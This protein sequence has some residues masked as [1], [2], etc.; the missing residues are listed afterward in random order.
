MW[1]DLKFSVRMLRQT[2]AFS[3]LAIF[4]IA[5]GIGVNTA[6]F[7]LVNAVLFR[8]PAVKAPGE[9]R[10]VYANDGAYSGILMYR[11]YQQLR[12]AAD[13]FVD[14]VAVTQD[15]AKLGRGSGVRL[16]MGE[17]VSTN[18]FEVLGV[19]PTL[20]RPFAAAIDEAVGA[21]PAAIISHRMWVNDFNADPSVLGRTVSLTRRMVR[22]DRQSPVY[23]I[24]G[25]APE[26]FDGVASPWSPTEFWVPLVQRVTDARREGADGVVRAPNPDDGPVRLC[27][28]RLKAGRTSDEVRAFVA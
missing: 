28:G 16:A 7:S 21:Q 1:N 15:E 12:D 18:Y 20:G 5:L 13:M 3:L 26:G 8:P 27:I 4:V 19:V 6:I 17:A 9:L 23:T 25:V 22:P 2:P 10:Y 14:I 11:H 24:V